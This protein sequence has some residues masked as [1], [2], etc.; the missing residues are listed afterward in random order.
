MRYKGKMAMNK[1]LSKIT[2]NVNGLHTLIKQHKV[3]ECIRKHD[4]YICSLNET[5]SEQ[6]IYTGWK[7]R[8]GKNIPCK[9]RWKKK[10]GLAIIIPDKTDFKAKAITRGKEG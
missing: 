6:K 10:A 1:Y 3:A 8:D 9:C 5:T 2:V 4:S 7:W